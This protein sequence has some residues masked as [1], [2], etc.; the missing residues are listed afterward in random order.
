MVMGTLLDG[1]NFH[2]W[3]LFW[4]DRTM[5]KSQN[6]KTRLTRE[7][8]NVD[9]KGDILLG[10]KSSRKQKNHKSKSQGQF[11]VANNKEDTDG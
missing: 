3:D 5:K 11:P 1:Y 6:R 2:S 9:S 7:D 4:E 8:P 10:E